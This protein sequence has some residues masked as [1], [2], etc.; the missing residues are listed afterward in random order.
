MAMALRP[1]G[2]PITSWLYG[3]LPEFKQARLETM[4]RW[5]REYGD[6][7]GL[8]FGHRRIYLLSHPDL[9]QEV[10]VEQATNFTKHFS[11]RMTPLIL[12]NGLLTSEGDFWRRQ[13]RLV[14]PAFQKSR[15]ASYAPVM[16]EY[17]EQLLKGWQPGDKRNIHAEMSRLTLQIAA[18]TLFDADA[19]DDA[20][21][22]GEAM[23]VMQESFIRLFNRLVPIPLFIPTANN[24]RI[25]RAARQLDDIIYGFIRQRRASKVNKS[26][27]LSLLLNARDEDNSRMTD[28]QVR[29]EAMT[30][31]LAGH[32]TTALALSWTWYCL[33]QN[34]DAEASL[35]AEVDTVL[36]GTLPTFA[37]WSKLRFTEA[38]VL[39]AMRLYPPAYIVG[40]EASVPC[41]IGGYHVPKGTTLLMSEWV[42]Q[43]DPRFYDRP[44]DFRPWRWLDGSTQTMPRYAYF[45]FGGGP[46]LCVGR[47]FAMMEMVLVLAT[48][49][50][51]YRFTLEPGQTV[52]PNPAFTL[53]PDPGVPAVLRER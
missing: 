7:V 12:G 53:H 46:R 25:K 16:V 3:N 14:Q 42:V 5:A 49:A 10:L 40:R 8:R 47:D 24:I 51:R 4:T 33:S 18:K 41:D 11:L 39:E 27:L 45:P 19:A 32:E 22:V 29:D 48:I 34:P 17:T 21:H 37:D 1:N 23:Q 13:R 20:Q 2:P 43:R 52:K 30:L 44:N 31:F 50:Q 6:V 15:I 28:K 9:I 26:D 36:Q 35:Q 38:V